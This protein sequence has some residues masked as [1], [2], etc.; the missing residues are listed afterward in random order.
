MPDDSPAPNTEHRRLAIYRELFFNNVRGFVE[1]AYPLLMQLLPDNQWS[2]L[3][4]DFF[5][6]H[7]CQSPLFRDIALEFRSWI[8]ISRPALFHEQ[9]WI[10]EVLHYEWVE[11]AAECAER[12][13]PSA[14]QVV[15][16]GDLLDGVPVVTACAWLLVYRWPVHRLHDEPP[17]S[18]PP[19]MPTFLIA[20]RN[21]E[22]RVFFMEVSALTARLMELLQS[23]KHLTGRAALEQ[24]AQASPHT[25]IADFMSAGRAALDGLR[26]SGI[27]RGIR[28]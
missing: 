10:Q 15:S 3:V 1:N 28:P 2:A 25:D 11:L 8:E 22:D 9:P 27:L 20:F 18:V 13:E 4:S 6:E 7:R 21:D 12:D 26:G 19:A 14:Q 24:L 23:D 17:Q 5:S 16:D